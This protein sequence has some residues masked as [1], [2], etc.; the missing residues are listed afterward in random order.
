MFSHLLSASS[1]WL[2]LRSK[3]SM[4]ASWDHL[5]HNVMLF[6]IWYYMWSFLDLASHL[7]PL[8]TY[9]NLTGRILCLSFFHGSTK[10]DKCLTFHLFFVCLSAIMLLYVNCEK[11]ICWSVGLLYVLHLYAI[12][13]LSAILIPT[14]IT[15]LTLSIFLRNRTMHLCLLCYVF[16][17]V[18]F[19]GRP[20]HNP[21]EE[22]YRI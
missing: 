13:F 15:F 11:G 18:L 1:E 19:L 6:T 17:F 5:G 14:H 22:L 2:L 8:R 16:F 10:W 7:L 12:I 3:L 9:P 21:Q 20:K 4:D